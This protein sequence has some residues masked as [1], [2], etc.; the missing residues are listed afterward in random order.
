MKWLILVIVIIGLIVG[1]SITCNRNWTA[2]HEDQVTIL[3]AVK[4]TYGGET[5]NG[6]RKEIRNSLFWGKI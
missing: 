5:R 2:V 6:T 3:D 1:T 4:K